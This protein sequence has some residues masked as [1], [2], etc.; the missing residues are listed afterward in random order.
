MRHSCDRFLRGAGLRH[1]ASHK[2]EH[3]Q[4]AQNGERPGGAMHDR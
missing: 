2:V 4:S 1:D 3:Q